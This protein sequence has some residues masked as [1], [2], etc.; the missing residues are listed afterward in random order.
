MHFL[1]IILPPILR[2]YPGYGPVKVLIQGKYVMLLG[3][4][5]KKKRQGG[6]VTDP[7]PLCRMLS[8]IIETDQD[9]V[10]SGEPSGGG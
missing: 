1:S 3:L 5:R 4:R 7:R 9:L 8:K 2:A 6:V 10:N